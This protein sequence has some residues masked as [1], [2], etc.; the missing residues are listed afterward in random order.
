M[1]LGSIF[2]ILPFPIT[3]DTSIFCYN[4]YFDV[5]FKQYYSLKD[6]SKA[7]QSVPSAY[8]IV[9]MLDSFDEGE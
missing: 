4:P 3:C 5:Q 7:V 2:R 8:K 9:I 6:L 1:S